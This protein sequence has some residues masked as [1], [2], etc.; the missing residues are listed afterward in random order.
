MS[1]VTLTAQSLALVSGRRLAGLWCR[2]VA[3]ALTW[4]SRRRSAVN[5]YRLRKSD[6]AAEVLLRTL[7]QHQSI[8]RRSPGEPSVLLA[9]C[10]RY[11]LPVCRPTC[12]RSSN[13]A[14]RARPR[15]VTPQNLGLSPF[16]ASHLRFSLSLP[17]ISHSEP[18]RLNRPPVKQILHNFTPYVAKTLQTAA[19]HRSY[20]GIREPCSG[21]E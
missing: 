6:R 21:F 14:L 16:A 15:P 8:P 1:N 20:L 12:R 10:T 17:L 7:L 9:G 2:G 3:S 13:L 19:F 5:R 4:R 18:E 11:Y